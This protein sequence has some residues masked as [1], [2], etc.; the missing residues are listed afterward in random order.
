MIRRAWNR[1]VREIKQ[2]AGL[3]ASDFSQKEAAKDDFQL[4]ESLVFEAFAAFSKTQKK[5]SDS[6]GFR[7]LFGL[8]IER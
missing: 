4:C 1:K 8:G 3:K 2:E 6:G 5:R 7:P